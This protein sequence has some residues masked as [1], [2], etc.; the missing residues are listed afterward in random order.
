VE[1]AIILNGYKRKMIHELPGKYT[2]TF[3]L[4]HPFFGIYLYTNHSAAGRI[5][6]KNKTAQI[7]PFQLCDA[8]FGPCKHSIGVIRF[9]LKSYQ[10][11]FLRVA[12]QPKRFS[13][14][15]KPG[16]HL[17]TNRNILNEL[18]QGIG[19]VSIQLMTG[20]PSHLISK[21][22][23]ADPDFEFFFQDLSFSFID[24]YT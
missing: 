19:Q 10:T 13:G 16:L 22:A 9:R 3:F 11:G 8:V 15:A 2:D 7:F 20:I 14:N 4:R 5:A 12:D 1:P 23:T 17:G 21:Q 24:A 6:F 18:A